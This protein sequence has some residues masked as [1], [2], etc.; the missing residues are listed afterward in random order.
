MWGEGIFLT[1][2]PSHFSQN[3]CKVSYYTNHRIYPLGKGSTFDLHG[4]FSFVYFR[5]FPSKAH[6][7]FCS[8]KRS[9]YDTILKLY[10]IALMECSTGWKRKKEQE[11]AR[12]LSMAD[13][14]KCQV[15]QA[16]L[17][18]YAA[19]SSN[20]CKLLLFYFQCQVFPS[21]SLLPSFSSV[22]MYNT[23]QQ[24]L[25]SENIETSEEYCLGKINL[26]ASSDKDSFAHEILNSRWWEICIFH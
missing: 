1:R 2:Q 13:P 10:L 4:D 21:F 9:Q 24:F 14:G 25:N 18:V 19:W 26:C 12:I 16:L 15:T 7:V 22:A 6:L 11:K 5:L 23:W 17:S 8:T 20:Y 3:K